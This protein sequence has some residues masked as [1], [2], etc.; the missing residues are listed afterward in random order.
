[1]I[2]TIPSQNDKNCLK[3]ELCCGMKKPF[4]KDWEK[5]CKAPSGSVGFLATVSFAV[6]L[7]CTLRVLGFCFVFV[8]YQTLMR[9]KC[10]GFFYGEVLLNC[11]GV[12]LFKF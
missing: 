2:L 11:S 6:C 8:I 7:K 4:R 9:G 10:C 5:M 1:M 12:F 3:P